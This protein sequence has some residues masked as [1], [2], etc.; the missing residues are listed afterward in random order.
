MCREAACCDFGDHPCC[1][2]GVQLAAQVCVLYHGHTDILT[3]RLPLCVLT[4]SVQI[5]AGDLIG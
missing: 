5:L 4:L 3:P 2:A 1:P